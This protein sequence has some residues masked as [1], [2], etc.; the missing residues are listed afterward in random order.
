[1]NLK[2]PGA[3]RSTAAGWGR[4]VEDGNHRRYHG[5]LRV[6]Q[7]TV[8]PWGRSSCLLAAYPLTVYLP[9]FAKVGRYAMVKQMSQPAPSQMRK[10]G[11]R[12]RIPAIYIRR[13]QAPRYGWSLRI[14]HVSYVSS[15]LGCWNHYSIGTQGPSS[16]CWLPSSRSKH[17]PNHPAGSRFS[18]GLLQCPFV[19]GPSS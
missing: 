13:R 1:M 16:P 19:G 6:V 4:H 5:H 3:G 10:S 2:R 8:E 15:Q 9:T 7:R 18:L 17:V 11:P 12:T 14:Q